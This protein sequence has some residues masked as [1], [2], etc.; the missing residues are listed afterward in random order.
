MNFVD[1]NLLA[2]AATVGLASLFNKNSR[3]NNFNTSG[4]NGPIDLPGTIVGSLKDATNTTKYL[5]NVSRY[6]NYLTSTYGRAQLAADRYMSLKERIP[7]SLEYYDTPTSKKEVVMYINPEKMSIT[8]NKVI[9]KTYT[10]GG[11]YFHHYGDDVWTMTLSGTVGYAMMKGIEALEEIH[12]GTLLKYRN[13]S[14]STVHTN[15]IV[16]AAPSVSANANTPVGDLLNGALGKTGVGGFINRAITTATD[17]IG[18]TKN[19]DQNYKP[20]A[21]KWFGKAA[22]DRAN[23][24]LFG[25]IV[26]SAFGVNDMIASATAASNPITGIANNMQAAQMLTGDCTALSSVMKYVL[27]A[28]GTLLNG[29]T[30]GTTGKELLKSL[31]ADM[32]LSAMGMSPTTENLQS[33]LGMLNGNTNNALSVITKFLAGDFTGAVQQ[34]R[35]AT[36]TATSGNFYILSK[37]GTAELNDMVSSVQAFNDSRKI[38]KSKAASQFSDIQD[39]LTD[40]YRPR[41]VI[42]YF[43]DRVY[44]GHFNSFKY[45]RVAST[46][47]IQY[48][49]TFTITREVVI[50]RQPLQ[51][52]VQ[53]PSLGSILGTVA[54]GALVGNIFKRGEGSTQQVKASN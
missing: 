53:T 5:Q 30:N 54:A 51:T 42:I 3:S 2:N 37:I 28:S 46:L 14:A 33:T 19:S 43:D 45:N 8:T 48:D 7:F 10:R 31:A 17:A 26:Q 16:N 21:E 41:Q 23:G 1:Y 47:L 29:I 34:G 32:A 4:G 20:L 39:Q 49:M 6:N 15:K 18:L 52:Q 24:N 13:L 22:S 44:I 27:G 9:Q 12:S 35:I 25:A 40:L 11:I 36:N 50:G 38:D